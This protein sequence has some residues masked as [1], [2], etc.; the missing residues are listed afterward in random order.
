MAVGGEGGQKA[1]FPGLC[2]LV[3][4]GANVFVQKGVNITTAF[5]LNTDPVEESQ[6]GVGE[7]WGVRHP[8]MGGPEQVSEPRESLP[9]LRESTRRSKGCPDKERRG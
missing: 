4:V 3:C 7:G 5:P 9:L 2:L 8:T 6:K 1:L